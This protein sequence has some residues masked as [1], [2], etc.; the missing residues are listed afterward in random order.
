LGPVSLCARTAASWVKSLA[1]ADRNFSLFYIIILP[2]Y[3]ISSLLYRVFRLFYRLYEVPSDAFDDD[4]VEEPLAEVSLIGVAEFCYPSPMAQRL[5]SAAKREICSKFRAA[6]NEIS[7]RFRAAKEEI[8][9]TFGA[10]KKD[11]FTVIVASSSSGPLSWT[12]LL[13]K[14][15][16]VLNH[17]GKLHAAAS[18][19]TA[20]LRCVDARSSKVV[21]AISLCAKNLF[22]SLPL[23]LCSDVS[24]RRSKKLWSQRGKRSKTRR[25]RTQMTCSQHSI[26]SGL[27]FD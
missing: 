4:Y 22:E 21:F 10:A 2:F 3:R 20:D 9:L 11:V 7:S 27:L 13:L 25:M 24:A 16:Q 12:V 14:G 19:D 23:C 5:R 15:F 6:E 1:D 8:H 17:P 18:G 26:W